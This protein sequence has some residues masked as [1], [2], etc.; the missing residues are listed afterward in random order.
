[1]FDGGD[2]GN[3]RLVRPHGLAKN[4][5]WVP[6]NVRDELKIISCPP[7]KGVRCQSGG[8]NKFAYTLV[9][10][11]EALALL[12][13]DLSP[14]KLMEACKEAIRAKRTPTKRCCCKTFSEKPYAGDIGAT[15]LRTGGVSDMS[16][17]ARDMV[18]ARYDLLFSYA[19]GLEEITQDA[20]ELEV[21]RRI[22]EAQKTVGF[23]TMRS[24]DGE[25][26]AKWTTGFAI[27]EDIHVSSHKDRDFFASVVTAHEVDAGYD[28]NDS[29]IVYFCFPE[30]GH[31]VPLKPGM[32]NLLSS[33][34]GPYSS[35]KNF[36]TR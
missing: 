8:R 31:A 14:K 18:S 15:A 35:L 12:K 16:K 2:E 22:E 28:E 1:M 30:L 19:Q 17:S 10:R 20:S 32:Y 36:F 21:I 7:G 5:K 13:G 25:V 9:P 27:G 4:C 3:P 23:Q 11:H 24:S 34:C 29:V 26:T 33:I 6:H